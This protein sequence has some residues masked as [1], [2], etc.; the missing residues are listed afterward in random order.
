MPW[1]GSPRAGVMQRHPHDAAASRCT[2]QGHEQST[3]SSLEAVVDQL[4]G[5]LLPGSPRHAR[6]RRDLCQPCCRLC[7][8]GCLRLRLV[9]T[10]RGERWG[11]TLLCC[12][13]RLAGQQLKD[14]CAHQPAVDRSKGTA[15]VGDSQ[16][17]LPSRHRSSRCEDST[18]VRTRQCQGGQPNQCIG[19]GGALLREPAGVAWD[20]A[21]GQPA[22]ACRACSRAGK[23]RRAGWVVRVQQSM[24]SDAEALKLLCSR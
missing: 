20:Q 15:A 8:R 16:T 17:G 24:L 2:E 19:S 7:P 22:A 13:Q 10:A 14:P 11:E 12:L 4:D 5:G 3:P 18:R 21:R 9:C 23:E 1:L 6:C